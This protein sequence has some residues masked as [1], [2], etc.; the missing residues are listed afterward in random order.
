M[1]F[2]FIIGTSAVALSVVLRLSTV[3]QIWQ[4]PGPRSANGI[5]PPSYPASPYTLDI[6]PPSNFQLVTFI[7]RT[8]SESLAWIIC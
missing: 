3:R 1:A 2:L 5:D 7:V 4:P 6:V 8:T